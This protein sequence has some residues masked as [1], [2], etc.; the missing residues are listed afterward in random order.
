[1]SYHDTRQAMI[2][3]YVDDQKL[4][5]AYA[6]GQDD[7]AEGRPMENPYTHDWVRNAYKC[8]YE[9]YRE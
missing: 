9:E 1:M 4:L 3:N 2:D 5:D 7:A 6:H 8:G